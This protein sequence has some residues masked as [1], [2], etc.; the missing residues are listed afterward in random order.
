MSTVTS[1]PPQRSGGADSSS[2]FAS[3]GANKSRKGR[4]KFLLGIVVLAVIGIGAYMMYFR[5]PRGVIATTGPT[6]YPVTRKSFAIK[7]NEKGELEATRSVDV[8]CEVEGRSTIIWLIPEGNEV[9]KGDLL[10]KLASNEIE[11]KIRSEQITVQN[12]KASADAAQ[13]ELDIALD[14]HASDIRKAVLAVTNAKTELEKYQKGDYELSLLEKELALETAKKT[15]EQAKSTLIDSQEL[16]KK[17]FITERELESQQLDEYK[18]GVEVQ[19]AERSKQVFLEYDHPKNLQ[20]KQTDIEEA[21][22]DLERT[23]KK[24]EAEA[25]KLRSNAE[26]KQAEFELTRDRLAKLVEQQAKTEIRAPA[27]GLVVY[28]AEDMWRG[29]ERQ[30]AEGSEVYERQTIIQL[31]DTSEMKVKVRIHEAKTSKIAVGQ[32]ATVEVEGI[33]GVVFTGKVSKIA[34]LADSQNRWLNPNLKEYD[35]EITLDPNKSELKP[36]VTARAEILVRQVDD[37]VAV[38]VQAVYSRAGRTFV[39]SGK[40]E[41]SAEPVPVET[42]YSSDEFVEIRNGVSAGDDVLLAH[43][44]AMIAKLPDETGDAGNSAGR[45]PPGGGK[46]GPGAGQRG[47]GGGKDQGGKQRGSGAPAGGASK[48]APASDTTSTTERT[49][50]KS[51]DA[52]STEAESIEAESTDAAQPA[53][54]AESD[55]KATS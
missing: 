5:G 42:G 1:P 33:P 40:N 38:P 17:K 13:Q 34:P 7:L 18:A 11:D 25:A 50:G 52:T 47:A 51:T 36:G 39:F 2:A 44:A 14:Q 48:G 10:A 23:R 6:A 35:T 9:K 30:I 8:K 32:S 29:N 31:P 12:S 49:D 19:K 27:D 22:K 26:A 43:T 46:R 20:Q 4:G 54:N 41:R 55:T 16:F 45:R 24:S 37:V 53:E 21:E 28:F 3:R 15:W